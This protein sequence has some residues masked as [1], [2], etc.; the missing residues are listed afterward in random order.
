[1]KLKLALIGLL[2]LPTLTHAQR[3]AQSRGFGENRSSLFSRATSNSSLGDAARAA[4]EGQRFSRGTRA[5]NAFVGSDRSDVTTFVGSEQARTQGTVT[6]SVS[7][8]REQTQVRVNRARRPPSTTGRYQARLSLDSGLS[9][10]TVPRP[11]P[12]ALSPQRRLARFFSAQKRGAI[13][14]SGSNHVA[15]L[16]GQVESVRE[17]R[18]AGL[19]ASFEP[20]VSAVRNDLKLAPAKPQRRRQIPIPPAPK[21]ET[22]R[23]RQP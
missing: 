10:G 16:S 4:T 6:S 20:G 3:R 19:I 18:I 17:R 8:L 14:V 1:M 23:S 22:F 9:P 5:R 21:S 11:Q 7:G 2:L 13:V 12:D 15:T